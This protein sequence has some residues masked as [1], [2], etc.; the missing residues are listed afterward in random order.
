M[1][2]ARLPICKE[3]EVGSYPIYAEVM[4][5]ESASSVPGV[6]SWIIPLHLSSSIKFIMIYFQAKVREKVTG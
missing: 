1:I 3:S 5:L 6:M 4:P 2:D